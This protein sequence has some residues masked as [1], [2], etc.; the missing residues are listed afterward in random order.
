MD[1]LYASVRVFARF[2]IWFFFKAVE[3]RNA[4]RVPRQGSVLL[5]INHPNNLIDSLLVGLVL[6]RKVHYLAT[7]ALFRNPL[8]A[9]FLAAVG[10]IPVHRRQDDPDKMDRNV[11]TFE[12]CFAA[13]ARGDLIAIYPEGTTHA[14]P[15]VQRIKTGAARI[16]LEAEARH[17]GK[18]GLAVIPVGLTFEARK[19]FRSRVLVAF[20]E[21][22]PLA[23]YL[24]H[25]R[26]DS[27]KA[28]DALTTHIQWMMEAQVIHVERIDLAEVVREV[29]ALYRGDLVR[30]LQVERG[31]SPKQIDV[32][33]LSRAIVAAVHHFKT[34]DPERV[35]RI[36]QRIQAYTALLA[37]FRIKDRTVQGQLHVR[38]V[39][40]RLRR[41]GLGLLGLP[42]FLYGALV[43]ALPY[44]V[45]R[46]IARRLTHRETDYATA[47][48]LSSIVL[49][50]LFWGLETWAVARLADVRVAALFL[51]SLP[52]S[53]LLAYRYL[54]GLARLSHQLR[55]AR[56]AMTRNH[57]AARLLAERQEILNELDR[58]KRD[59]LAATRGS[60]F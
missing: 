30:E 24:E 16:A 36:W 17:E 41:S 12:A 22:I 21:P 4:E 55:F 6:P 33:R 5:C 37:E 27:W 35:E 48:L 26:D 28:V 7:A 2:W 31:L 32:F 34:H 15:R 47:R 56:L 53:G 52:L 3:V 10:V 45:P 58:A 29:E 57:A 59:Y 18:L 40:A 19:S 9:R 38:P 44:Y 20:G 60:T 23:P 51:A 54:G 14:E 46:I 43:N 50:P 1:L 49:F 42:I 39:P 13:L 25:Y 8:M 11:A